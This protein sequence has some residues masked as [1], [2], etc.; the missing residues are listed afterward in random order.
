MTAYVILLRESVEQDK[1]FSRYRALAPASLVGRGSVP[2][3]QSR[4][5][6]MAVLEGPEAEG[7][8]IF[9]FPSM[10]EARAWYDSPEYQAARAARDGIAVCRIIAVENDEPLARPEAGDAQ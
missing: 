3:A 6:E 5:G 1:D 7:V 10:A 4:T 9:T 8:T 2:L